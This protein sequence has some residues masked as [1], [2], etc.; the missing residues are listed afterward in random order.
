M[1]DGNR[2]N[3]GLEIKKIICLPSP[4]CHERCGLLVSVKDG[5]IVGIKGNPDYPSPGHGCADRMS[6]FAEWL[7]SSEQLLYPLKRK[8]ERG[9]NRW[10]RISWDQALDEIAAKLAKIKAEHGAE[11]L[12]LLE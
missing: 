9:E 12:A 5:R 7:Y 8:G 2:R 11:S 10:E 1:T 6:H 3:E 4:G